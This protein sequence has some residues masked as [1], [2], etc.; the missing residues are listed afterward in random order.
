MYIILYKSS[1]IY[2]FTTATHIYIFV[3]RTMLIGIIE[4]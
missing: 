1:H 2:I 3:Y 4:H